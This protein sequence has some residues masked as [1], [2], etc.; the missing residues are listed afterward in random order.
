M[1]GWLVEYRMLY[2][3]CTKQDVALFVGMQSVDNASITMHAAAAAA[4][5]AATAA[6]SG[7][8][9]MNPHTRLGAWY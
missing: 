5:A 4:A 2:V 6:V 7:V 9:F 3:C 8:R 1:A